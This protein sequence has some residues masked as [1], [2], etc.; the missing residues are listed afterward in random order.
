MMEKM[1]VH[2]I[3]NRKE[4]ERVHIKGKFFCRIGGERRGAR[5]QCMSVG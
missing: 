2:K 5:T 4:N 3:K 1:K